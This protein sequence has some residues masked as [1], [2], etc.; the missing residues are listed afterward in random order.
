V[1]GE[2]RV[3]VYLR[4]DRGF[5]PEQDAALAALEKVGQPVVHVAIA[6]PFDLGQ[7]LFRWE[8]AIAVAGSILGV[9][10]FDQPDVEA[11]K[12]AARSQLDEFERTGAM[13]SDTP[14]CR[15]GPL[16]LFAPER[17]RAMFE[18]AAGREPT[19][20]DYLRAHLDRVAPGDFVAL[21]AFLPRDAATDNG[22]QDIRCTIRDARRVATSVGFGPRFLHSTGQLHKGG[23]NTGIFLQLTCDEAVDL[24]VPNRRATFGVVTSS[25]ARGDLHVLAERGRRVVRIHISGAVAAGLTALGDELERA[26]GSR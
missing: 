23:P 24:S 2:D 14:L 20:R 4:L 9:N 10:P 8:M 5:Q 1:Y 25:Q 22:L 16:E 7:E 17:D 13:T 15:D 6:E 11:S 18:Q 12:T 21:L 26:L 19:L 3:F